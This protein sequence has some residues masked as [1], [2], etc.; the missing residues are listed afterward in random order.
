MSSDI[1][2]VVSWY[3]V[4]TDRTS[5]LTD[6]EIID[7]WRNIYRKATDMVPE[8]LSVVMAATDY[9]NDPT[10][11]ERLHNLRQ[12]IKRAQEQTR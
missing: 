11:I 9:A 4:V 5:G 10:S 8:L 6:D 3:R 2:R 12:A 7:I 1:D